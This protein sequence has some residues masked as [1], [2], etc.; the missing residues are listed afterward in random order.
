MFDPCL[1]RQHSFMEIDHEI[2]S[3]VIFYLLIQVGQLSVCGKR[4]CTSTG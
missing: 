3:M 1:V 2:F 4:M